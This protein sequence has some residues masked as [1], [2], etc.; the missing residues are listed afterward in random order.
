MIP[1]FGFFQTAEEYQT[2]TAGQVIFQEGQP[3]EVMYVLVAGEVYITMGGKRINH[4]RPG[5]IFGEM[6]LIE[7]GP[8]SATATAVTDAIIL[9]INR[10]QFTELLRDYPDFA[11]WVMDYMSVRSRRMM[12]EEV[13]LIHL[14]D[15]LRIGREIQMSLLPERCPTVAG[16]EFAAFYRP[17]RMVGGD[18]YDFIPLLQDPTQMNIFIADVTGKGVPAALFMALSR[19]ILHVESTYGYSPAETLQRVNHFIVRNSRNPLFLSIALFTVHTDTGRLIFAN[20]GHDRPLWLRQTT[21][22]VES[23]SAA[24]MLLG[25]FPEVRL[26]DNEV[27]LAPGDAIILYT[28]GITEAQNE[29]GELFGDERLCE[30]AAAH[31]GSSASQLLEGVVTAV[32]QFTGATPQADDL[33]LVVIKRTLDDRNSQLTS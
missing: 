7:Q 29:W 24:G 8:R 32:T 2:V 15:E 28:D 9:P 4:L 22:T 19:T 23:L 30:V 11:L 31:L 6:A 25:V 3:G 20:G 12:A 18:L 21:G 33:T 5:D 14:E 10:H 27:Q 1:G 16:W 26:A 17:A 13:K